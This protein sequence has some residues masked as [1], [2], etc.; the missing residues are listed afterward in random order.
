M[1]IS[2]YRH[3][4][5]NYSV[6]YAM[7]YLVT[8][9]KLEHV[10]QIRHLLILL[11]GYNHK[12]SDPTALGT[13]AMVKEMDFFCTAVLTTEIPAMIDNYVLLMDVLMEVFSLLVS[14]TDWWSEVSGRRWCLLRNNLKELHS[15][16]M[17]D[18]FCTTLLWNV[19]FGYHETFLMLSFKTCA[20]I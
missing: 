12:V 15:F 13:S 6:K 16:V 4:I 8:E 7:Q 19:L 2:I 3:I 18:Q 14:T 9:K 1:Q 20:P 10:Y 5:D 11:F 17:R